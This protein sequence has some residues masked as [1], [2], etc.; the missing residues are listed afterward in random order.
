M[1]TLTHVKHC[2]VFS[3]LLCVA[4][5]SF[6]FCFNEEYP[7]LP[8]KEFFFF[9]MMQFSGIA[10]EKNNWNLVTGEKISI[11]LCLLLKPYFLYRTCIV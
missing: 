4:D 9:E 3:A 11:L 2:Y 6:P 7:S 5:S 8:L 1:I 10:N